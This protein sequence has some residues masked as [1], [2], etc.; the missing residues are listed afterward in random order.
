MDGGHVSERERERIIS[1]FGHGPDRNEAGLFQPQGS[2]PIK[3]FVD[4]AYFP[5]MDVETA[6]NQERILYLA[7]LFRLG[8]NPLVGLSVCSQSMESNYEL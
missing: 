5:L 2:S 1:K 3:K 4:T 6:Q 7:D 8:F